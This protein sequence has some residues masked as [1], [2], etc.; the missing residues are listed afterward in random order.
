MN[1][2]RA[3]KGMMIIALVL[4]V[5]TVLLIQPLTGLWVGLLGL[6]FFL[7]ATGL[8]ITSYGESTSQQQ[9]NHNAIVMRLDSLEK[10]LKDIVSR[11]NNS[12]G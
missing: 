4:A 6:V 2:S 1:Y 3:G 10:Q 9:E 11:L 8:A 12:N 5:C 7:Y